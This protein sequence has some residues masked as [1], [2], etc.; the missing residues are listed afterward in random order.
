MARGLNSWKAQ[1]AA[2]RTMLHAAVRLL[3]ARLVRVLNTWVHVARTRRET[4]A[5]MKAIIETMRGSKVRAGLNQWRD[6]TLEAAA[7]G[8]RG[9]GQKRGA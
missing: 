7:R 2:Y 4:V 8:R 1:F 6:N 5:R 3:S 9:E